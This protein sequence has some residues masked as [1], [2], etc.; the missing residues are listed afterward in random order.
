MRELCEIESTTHLEVEAEVRYWED[1]SVNGVV[2]VDG[3]LIPGRAGDLWKVRIDLSE[4]RIEGWPGVIAHIHY[5]V[6]DAGEYFLTDQEGRRIAKWRGHY[7]PS[8]ILCPGKTGSDD[9]IIMTVSDSG[10]IAGYQRSAISH[11][12]WA[13]IGPG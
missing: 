9:Y 7:V 12:R 11:E 2:D 6:C 13:P 10:V 8:S 1:A 5:K 4:G 3:N